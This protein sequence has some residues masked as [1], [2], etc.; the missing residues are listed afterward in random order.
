M[1]PSILSTKVLIT[2]GTGFLGAYVIKELVQKN[3]SVRAIRRS[4]KLPFYIPPNIFDAVE[5]IDGDILDVVA[6]ENAMK[7][8]DAVMHAAAKV[9]FTAG[10]RNEMLKTNA[11]GTANVVNAAISQNVKKFIHVSSVAVLGR[12]NSEEHINES[13]P[14]KENAL[15]TNYAVS[16]YR[17]EMEVWRA[18]GEGLNAV[19]V[20][21]STIIGYG[22]WNTSSPAIFKSVY[23]EFPWYSNGINSFVDVEDVAKAMVLLLESNINAERFILGCD[24]YSFRKLFDLI[25]DGFNKKHPSKE[26]TPFLGELAWRLEKVKSFFSGKPSILTK[27]TARV[28]QSKTYFENEKIK[29]FLPGFTFTPLEQTISNACK[30]YESHMRFA[31]K[32]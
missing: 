13:N 9:S 5:W 32:G 11:E 14:W 21:P 28:A 8:V 24:N 22:D 18:I 17:A 15:T 12:T 2:G 29:T 4:S 26:A 25:A 6:L 20:N 23:N 19:I 31:Q 27:E 30:A 16:K 10:G 7:G 1:Q 3:Y